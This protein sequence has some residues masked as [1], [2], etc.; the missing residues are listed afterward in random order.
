MSRPVVITVSLGII[1]P[2]FIR[3][4]EVWTSISQDTMTI[5]VEADPNFDSSGEPNKYKQLP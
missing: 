5:E 3:F 2:P 4:E 1:H